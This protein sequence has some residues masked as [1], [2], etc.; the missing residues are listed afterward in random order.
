MAEFLQ[1]QGR[2][3]GLEF[4]FGSSCGADPVAAG[5]AGGERC[6]AARGLEYACM[7]STK[8]N[9]FQLVAVA[10]SPEVLAHTH[11][12]TN[13]NSSSACCCCMPACEDAYAFIHQKFWL[14]CMC[15]PVCWCC[16]G[17]AS[18]EQGHGFGGL[19]GADPVAAGQ[20][21]GERCCA[22]RGLEYACMSS[23]KENAFQLVAVAC[24]PEVLAHT[25]ASTN[26]NSSSACCCWVEIVCCQRV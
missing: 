25:R 12:S 15:L 14:T 10:C 7:S 18:I 20:A 6:C 9:A 21:G 11:A 22:A 4:G 17:H 8:E 3:H 24:S 13:L 26:L 1:E 23:T 2:R 16:A 5:Q 19:L